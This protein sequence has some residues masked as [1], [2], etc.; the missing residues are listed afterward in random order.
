MNNTLIGCDFGSYKLNLTYT[1]NNNE[2][3]KNIKDNNKTSI[4]YLN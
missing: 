4:M 1:E 2:N 3:I